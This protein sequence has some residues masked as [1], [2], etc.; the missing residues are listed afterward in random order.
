MQRTALLRGAS[1]CALVLASLATAEAQVALPQ[2]VIGAP[3]RTAAPATPQKPSDVEI[4]DQKEIDKE[5]PAI[6]DTTKLLEN[7]PGVSMYEAG[8]VSR[9]PAIH[10]MA[11][12]RLKIIVG[13]VQP[14]SACANHMNP[15]LSY[16][17]P[18]NVQKIEVYSG[19]MPVSK[20]GDSIGGS[21]IVTPKQP[22]FAPPPGAPLPPPVV[23][24]VQPF[25]LGSPYPPF[26]PFT[27]QGLRFGNQNELLATG[28]VSAFFRSNYNGI[29]VAGTTNVA[30]DHWSVLYNG[31]WSRATDYHQGGNG[32]K[33]LS[34]NFI[35]EQHSLTGAYQYNGHLFSIR[36]AVEHI[37]YQ[38]F[39]NQRM[40]M[41]GN[42]GYTA[43]AKYLGA[44]DWGLVDARAFWHHV[45]HTMGF[46]YDK[47]PANMPMNTVAHDFG[48][49]VKTEIPF[50]QL[51]GHD[52]LRLGSEY[53]GFRLNDWW[54]P[55][56]SPTMMMMGPYTYWNIN[57]GQRNRV[58]HYAE[59]EA[60]WT[61]QWSTLLGLRNDVVWMTTGNAYPY[62]QRNP[63]PMGMMGGMGGMGGMMMYMQNPDAPA[64]RI[65]NARSHARTDVNFDMV[66]R[67]RY[68]PDAVS[69]YEI[70]YSRKT[71]SP[72]LY[73]RYAWGVGSMATAMVNWFGDL[74][75]YTGNLDLKP[76]VAHTFGIVGS[77]ID[78]EGNWEARVNPYYSYIENFIDA[79][80]VSNLTGPSGLVFPILQ[81]RNHKAEIYGFDVSGRLKLWETP[82]Y[83]LFSTTG[84]ISYV[85]GKD[86]DMPNYTAC[87]LSGATC[88]LLARNF[89]KGDGLYHIM[90]LTA[91][92]ALEHRLGGWTS[93]VELQLVDSKTHVSVAR[94]ELKTG[95]YALVNLR[96]A[97]D[98]GTMRFD[99]AVEN[100]F[101]QLYYPPL[102]GSYF[103][104]TKVTGN[105]LNYGPVPGIGRN[106]V[107]GLTVRF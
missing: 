69:T 21:I 20:G 1:A 25:L 74:N 43:E 46:L 60:A 79:D 16:I 63:I 90:P 15:P 81:F 5:K 97:Y 105:P 3:Q 83:G 8:G 94:N 47:Q 75:G 36:G 31:A 78:P 30:T 22:V 44:Y 38:G 55:V 64:S 104:L 40:D 52:L 106:F 68:Q 72:N 53:H 91:R 29:S 59:W 89:S 99:F 107:A 33:V 56:Y 39:P 58:G 19:V 62:N 2:I 10:G 17:D 32:P 37:P 61:P 96:T 50:T 76:E 18:N 87:G 95:G 102:G 57:N 67:A 98:W 23:A 86:L 77:W 35:S 70:G 41:T 54:E 93:A 42:R 26:L 80:R 65:F 28:V 12:D 27:G 84:S 24:P 103:T 71:R 82:E 13:G 6:A 92:G 11:D 100:L 85:Y 66:A 48:Y 101:D 49:S 9:L 88:Y 51:F 7:T 34:T 4:V 73:E 14:T 45:T